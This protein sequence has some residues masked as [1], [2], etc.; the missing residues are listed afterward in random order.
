MLACSAG[1]FFPHNKS[2]ALG[3]PFGQQSQLVI[4]A[5][6]FCMG[7]EYKGIKIFLES[8]CFSSGSGSFYLRLAGLQV[9]SVV[10]VVLPFWGGGDLSTELS[11]E[12]R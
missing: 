2:P 11:T 6:G 5:Q 4:H 9:V 8:F 12:T 3:H 10:V 7:K 1:T